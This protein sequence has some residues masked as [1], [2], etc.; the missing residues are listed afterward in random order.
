MQHKWN[1]F[2]TVFFLVLAKTTLALPF[3]TD[4]NTYTHRFKVV[5]ATKK[6][7]PVY[8]KTFTNMEMLNAPNP[9]VSGENIYL[10]SFNK[11][12]YILYDLRIGDE[13]N[14]QGQCIICSYAVFG[15]GLREGDGSS[16]FQCY[17][18]SDEKDTYLAIR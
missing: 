15:E 13:K 2:L 9:I 12:A 8:I 11:N 18:V 10:T 16:G 6:S 3:N 5:N 17:M 14:P 4:Q 1:F 7:I